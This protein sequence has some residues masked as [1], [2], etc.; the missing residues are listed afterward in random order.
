MAETH[1]IVVIF[2]CISQPLQRL[3]W[4]RAMSEC[5]KLSYTFPGNLHTFFSF[6]L[7]C[8]FFSLNFLGWFSTAGMKILELSCVTSLWEERQSSYENNLVIDH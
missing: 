7:F 4:L 2:C 6:F 8:A 1:L 5:L 3:F